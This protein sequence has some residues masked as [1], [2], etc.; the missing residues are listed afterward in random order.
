MQVHAAASGGAALDAL[1][2]FA[3]DAV[4]LDVDMPGMDGFATCSA[5]MDRHADLPVIFMT[6][7]GET[8]HIVRGFEVG[9]C[10]YVTKPVVIA[11]WWRAC[12]H[13]GKA[14][15]ARSAREAVLASAV[16]MCAAGPD[17][18]LLW[19]QRQRHGAAAGT[20]GPRQPPGRHCRPRR[21][22]FQRLGAAA[23]DGQA[24]ADGGTGW[25]GSADYA[26]AA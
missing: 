26:C 13:A 7:L 14:R 9:A 16:P 1:A 23:Q 15:L 2:A 4:L 21:E 3:P 18:R 8:R 6:G 22:A 5:M 12:A 19:S 17:G 10:D 11:G 20:A 25:T 24:G